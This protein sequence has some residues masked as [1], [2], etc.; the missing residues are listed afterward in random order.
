[1]FE[2]AASAVIEGQAC[3]IQSVRPL[4]IGDGAYA[5]QLLCDAPL[6]EV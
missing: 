2:A 5:W 6:D 1:M 3:R 4:D